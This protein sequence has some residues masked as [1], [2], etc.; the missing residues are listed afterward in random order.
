[1]TSFGTKKSGRIW[2]SQRKPNI[3]GDALCMAKKLP[4][5][6]DTTARQKRLLALLED[7]VLLEGLP[8]RDL[9]LLAP[10]EA[11]FS[12]VLKRMFPQS[13][14]KRKLSRANIV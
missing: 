2:A 6:L 5:T 13:Q 7:S 10:L 11:L 1:M 12:R 9:A 8:K 14:L 3:G 4:K